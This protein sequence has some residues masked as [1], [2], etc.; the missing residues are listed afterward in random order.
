MPR[1]FYAILG[2]PRNATSEQLRQRFRDL[3][4]QR[5][6]D[7]FQGEA[8]LRAEG[9]FQ[10]ITQAFNMLSDPARRRQHDLELS[11]P[12]D[13][14]ADPRQVAKVY[15][16]RGVKAY[17]EKNFFEAAD[18]FDRATR[19]DTGNAQAWHHLALACSQNPRWLDRAVEAVER[20][21]EIEPMN[22]GYHKL[23]GR[24]MA[25]AGRLD[26]AEH[27]YR[28]A[29]DWGDDDPAVRRA[30]EE[31]TRGPRRGL[32]GSA[33]GGSGGGGVG[34]SGGKPV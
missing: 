13:T 25:V 21:C 9:E 23:A 29:L 15:L 4:R 17:K 27:H 28:A 18:N 20:A 10:E 11:R 22:A 32:F 8:K 6:P 1:D 33:I 12:Q 5:H 19:E 30:L 26:R 24:I 7:R 14:P 34:G 16:Q 2:V 31:M 3:A